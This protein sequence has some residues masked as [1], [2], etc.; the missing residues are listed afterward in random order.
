[1][2]LTLHLK[3]AG[4][5]LLLLA[6]AHLFFPRYFRWKEDLA[7]LTLLNRQMFYVHCFFIVLVLV[8]FG[9]LS[10]FYTAALLSPGPLPKA[11]LTGFVVFWSVRLFIQFFV[12]DSKLWKGD[13][14]N[15]RIHILFS[16]LWAYYVAVY[17]CALWQQ[18]HF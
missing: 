2:N 9:L 17:A 7:K 6:F 16:A 18:F 13:S 14:F 8:L 5:L 4:A 3:L 1:M 11:V 10:L 15:T 12:Y